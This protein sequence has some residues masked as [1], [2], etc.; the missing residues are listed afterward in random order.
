MANLP[1]QV[2]DWTPEPELVGP[3]PRVAVLSRMEII[4]RVL[5]KFPL[6]FLLVFIQERWL[7]AILSGWAVASVVRTEWI[8]RLCKSLVA[9][10]TATRGIVSERI[11]HKPHRGFR[12]SYTYVI[13][14][15]T[16]A[17]GFQCRVHDPMS[18]RIWRGDTLTVLYLPE[19]PKRA[20]PYECCLYK[21]VPPER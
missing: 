19:S 10:G 6:V 2:T 11:W 15:E 12:G 7:I 21:A 17:G 16:P 18:R 14:Y 20:M 8:R 5:P 1:A 3:I 9:R 13:G 4:V